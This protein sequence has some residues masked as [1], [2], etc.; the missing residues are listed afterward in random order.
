VANRNNNAPD[1]RNNNV[2]FRL[3]NTG[4]LP[5]TAVSTDAVGVAVSVQRLFLLRLP[6]GRIF[7]QPV[8]LVT[9]RPAP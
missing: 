7:A 1:N 2:G 4:K 5:G 8:R 6:T 9:V 3:A